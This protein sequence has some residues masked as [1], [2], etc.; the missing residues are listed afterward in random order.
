MGQGKDRVRGRRADLI[1]DPD[2]F[3]F[4]LPTLADIIMV[5]TWEAFGYATFRYCHLVVNSCMT[6]SVDLGLY[7]LEVIN[8]ANALVLVGAPRRLG[9]INSYRS[10]H[11]VTSCL[12]CCLWER[13]CLESS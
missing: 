3:I 10:G 6:L 5:Q 7:K 13:L 4:S 9:W 12:S 8:S 2:F 1:S 11:R